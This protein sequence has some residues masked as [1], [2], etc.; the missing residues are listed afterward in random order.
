MVGVS[1]YDRTSIFLAAKARGI[2]SGTMLL[3]SRHISQI[4][5]GFAPPHSLLEDDDRARLATDPSGTFPRL[6]QYATSAKSLATLRELLPHVDRL[7]PEQLPDHICFH[8]NIP[9]SER[10]EALILDALSCC[11]YNPEMWIAL[12]QSQPWV[13]LGKFG[14]AGVYTF[15]INLIAVESWPVVQPVIVNDKRCYTSRYWFAGREPANLRI[16]WPCGEWHVVEMLDRDD[17]PVDRDT[18]RAELEAWD[19]QCEA[20]EPQS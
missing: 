11:P 7:D 19:R 15:A 5:A 2:H 8:Q 10:L 13:E 18:V 6:L 16:S 3:S 17:L 20:A 14:A 1:F 12:Y 4:A 9:V